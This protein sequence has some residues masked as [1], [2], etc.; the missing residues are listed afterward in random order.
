M[1]FTPLAACYQPST[2][3]SSA[4]TLDHQLLCAHPCETGSEENTG[5]KN[6]H[7]AQCAHVRAGCVT[8]ALTAQVVAVARGVWQARWVRVG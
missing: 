8:P 3:R 6:M 5:V 7:V 2:N 1:G 4:L